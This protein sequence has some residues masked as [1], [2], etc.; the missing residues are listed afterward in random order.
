MF[1]KLKKASFKKCITLAVLFI[2]IGIAMVVLQ[3]QNV[4]YTIFGYADFTQLA[5]DE[6]KSQLVEIDL[7]ANFGCFLEEYER[8]TKTNAKKTTSLYY[9]ISTLYEYQ[10]SPFL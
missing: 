7:T 10:G 6:I 8:N 3:A 1:E 2:L 5:P 4:F 9:V